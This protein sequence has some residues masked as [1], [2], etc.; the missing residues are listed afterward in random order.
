MDFTA[1]AINGFATKF[2][3]LMDHMEELLRASNQDLARQIARLIK[4][5]KEVCVCINVSTHHC[6][7]CMISFM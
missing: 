2:L 3:D 6:L 4:I 1:K 7:N 5:R